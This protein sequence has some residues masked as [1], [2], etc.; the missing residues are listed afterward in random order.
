MQSF[1]VTVTATATGSFT[2]DPLVPGVTPVRAVHFREL[3]TRIDA[4]RERAGLPRFGWT[5]PVL[6]A[7][8][9]PVRIVHLLELQSALAAVYEAVG[10][11]AAS[12]TERAR[13]GA[14]VRAAH[15]MELRAAVVALE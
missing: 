3:R 9:T 1:R 10:Q 8:L 5:D 4:L 11:S 7:G 14:A 2:D 6:E 15:L 12:Y 13:A